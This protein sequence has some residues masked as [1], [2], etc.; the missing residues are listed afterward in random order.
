MRE[1]FSRGEAAPGV[2]AR[3][4]IEGDRAALTGARRLR[5]RSLLISLALE[6][7]LLAALVL[8]PLLATGSRRIYLRMT[9]VPPRRGLPRAN[10]DARS[11]GQRPP[12]GAQST[13]PRRPI[14]QPPH[15][16]DKVASNPIGD[17]APAPPPGTGLGP[18]PPGVPGGLESGPADPRS[19]PELPS[20]PTVLKPRR[21]PRPV[22]S[23]GVQQALLERRVEPTYPALAKQI[24]LEGTVQL[25]ALIARDGAVRA[26]EV[27]SGHPILAQAALAAVSQWRYR[28]SL[29]NGEPVEVETYVTVIFQLER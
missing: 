18:E 25:H 28:P 27:L 17:V 6:A 3:C 19:A 8:V 21:G 10:R 12:I 9:P 5:R 7:A 11:G 14:Y 23:E 4:L 26:L 15:I 2:L 13:D 1:S 29:L 16:P 20:A 24:H 22:V